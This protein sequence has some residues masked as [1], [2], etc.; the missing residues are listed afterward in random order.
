MV[1]VH[2]SHAAQGSQ[3]RHGV[4]VGAFAE[5][6]GYNDGTVADGG[7]SFGY[8]V[9]FFESQN[10]LW[11]IV[12][13]I[14]LLIPTLRRIEPSGLPSLDLSRSDFDVWFGT[15]TTTGFVRRFVHGSVE[16]QLGP[17]LN[18]SNLN[19]GY[20]VSA[21]NSDIYYI[22]ETDLTLYLV[23]YSSLIL[24]SNTGAFV[25]LQAFLGPSILRYSRIQV[26]YLDYPDVTDSELRSFSSFAVVFPSVFIG[27]RF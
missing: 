13:L 1:V 4:A 11:G 12:G 27:Y 22:Q 21:I 2:V 14:D 3:I 19:A 16:F 23:L 8:R 9:D 18:L 15:S 17:G 25:G 24:Q 10:S 6:T 20:P 7:Y 5:A 26:S